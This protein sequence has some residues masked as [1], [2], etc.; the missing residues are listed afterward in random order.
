VN[1]ETTPLVPAIAERTTPMNN[2]AAA[3][4]AL[5]GLTQMFGHLPAPYVTIHTQSQAGLDLQ[6]SSPAAF[7]AWRTA[8][9]VPTD[10]IVLKSYAGDSWLAAVAVFCGVRIRLSGHGVVLETAL[11]AVAA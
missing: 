3:A 6:L 4:A 5:L 8:L 1:H 11:T 10:D 2:Q 9:V 7:E